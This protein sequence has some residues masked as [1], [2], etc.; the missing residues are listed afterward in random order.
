MRQHHHH[1]F[2]PVK[3]YRS[4]R[5]YLATL[6]ALLMIGTLVDKGFYE[7]FQVVAAWWGAWIII[8]YIKINGIPGTKGWLS[9]DWAEWIQHRYN[10]PNGVK[11]QESTQDGEAYDPLWKDKD[12]V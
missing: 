2:T 9:N 8:Q 1:Q 4:L 3:F 12:L 7:I 11:N 5:S 10:H 6:F